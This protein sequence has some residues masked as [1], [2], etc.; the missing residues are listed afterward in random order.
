MNNL[1]AQYGAQDFPCAVAVNSV[2]DGW[3]VWAL[4]GGQD[5]NLL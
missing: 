3:H 1:F 4:Y 5:A 2:S